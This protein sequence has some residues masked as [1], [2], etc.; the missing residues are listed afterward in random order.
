[1]SELPTVSLLTSSTDRSLDEIPALFTEL[2]PDAPDSVELYVFRDCD[3]QDLKIK[4]RDDP[5]ASTARL[6]GGLSLSRLDEI[7]A[8]V[9]NRLDGKRIQALAT[10]FPEITSADL[11]RKDDAVKALVNAVYL[12]DK[13]RVSVVEMVAGRH[14]EEC[15]RICNSEDCQVVLSFRDYALEESESSDVNLP[16]KMNWL[17]EGLSE[18]CKRVGDLPLQHNVQLYLEM[19]PGRLFVLSRPHLIRRALQ[20]SPD[21]YLPY[22]DSNGKETGL[23]YPFVSFNCDIGHC[24]LMMRNGENFPGGMWSEVFCGSAPDIG[25]PPLRLRNFHISDHPFNRMHL[26]RPPTTEPEYLTWNNIRADT[27]QPMGFIPWLNCALCVT[28]H[29]RPANVSLELEAEI[30]PEAI[31]T[32]IR[33]VRTAL[34]EIAAKKD[35]NPNCACIACEGC[36]AYRP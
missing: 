6:V 1:M 23:T 22:K 28:E 36:P 24:L 9:T 13:L 32:G 7:A 33:A 3:L 19:E 21:C 12:A 35:E 34:Q 30:Y 10:Y 5:R 25:T 31:R 17:I 2:G 26:D 18:V 4:G 8:D 29:G 20:A 27:C 16:V 14:D 15:T 11:D